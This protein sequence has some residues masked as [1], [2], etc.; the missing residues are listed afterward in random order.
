MILAFSNCFNWDIGWLSRMW[1]TPN[2]AQTREL[3]TA[4]LFCTVRADYDPPLR[5]NPTYPN[6]V[7]LT[8]VLSVR[9][10]IE[11]VAHDRTILCELSECGQRVNKWAPKVGI[12]EELAIR[13]HKNPSDVRE[14]LTPRSGC[15]SIEIRLQ[16]RP[17]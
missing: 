3:G 4:R 7:G 16:P 5:S 6:V 13:I 8:P 14:D 12:E 15:R 17:P 9:G 11:K 1:V 10:Q 2:L